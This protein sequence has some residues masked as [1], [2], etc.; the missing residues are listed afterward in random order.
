MKDSAIKRLLGIYDPEGKLLLNRDYSKNGRL[1][2]RNPEE[3]LGWL[4]LSFEGGERV[5]VT[6]SNPKGFITAYDDCLVGEKSIY[7]LSIE[8][9]TGDDGFVGFRD[10]ELVTIGRCGADGKDAVT[11]KIEDMAES[12]SEIQRRGLMATV[13]KLKRMEDGSCERFISFARN[14]EKSAR[15]LL[16]ER[17]KVFRQTAGG[18]D[19]A[20]SFMKVKDD[21]LGYM[22]ADERHESRILSFFMP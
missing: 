13:K 8:R 11:Q 4:V 18:M 17:P 7:F 5:R 20:A 2:Y 10:S 6:R 16:G 12:E 19:R 14:Y 1:V 9:K 15:A 21:E 3:K 22:Q